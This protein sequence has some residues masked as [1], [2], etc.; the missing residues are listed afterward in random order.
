M[1]D[2]LQTKRMKSKIAQNLSYRFFYDFGSKGR[3][4]LAD[5]LSGSIGLKFV[6]TSACRTLADFFSRLTASR[7]GTESSKMAPAR[8]NLKLALFTLAFLRWTKRSRKRTTRTTW[9]KSSN[10]LVL[11][12]RC[13]YLE[14]GADFTFYFHHVGKDAYSLVSHDN[15]SL[16]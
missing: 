1:T 4:T 6:G 16:V 15:S 10:K 3:R 8:R 5:F 14:L 12:Y 9:V 11:V 13:P 7:L 2:F